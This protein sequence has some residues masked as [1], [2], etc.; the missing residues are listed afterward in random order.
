MTT[1]TVHRIRAQGWN[2]CLDACIAIVCP[3]P[4]VEE[5]RSCTEIKIQLESLRRRVM[6]GTHTLTVSGRVIE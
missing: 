2:A 3:S 1:E 4:H 6:I 5:E